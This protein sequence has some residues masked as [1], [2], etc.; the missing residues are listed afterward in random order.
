MKIKKDL[1]VVIVCIVLIMVVP[2]PVTYKDG[3]T[4]A[5]NALSYKI[6]KWNRLVA[7][8]E[9]DNE[10]VE[11]GCYH[12]T[13]VYLFPKNFM[14]IDWLYSKEY[15]KFEHKHDPNAPEKFVW[16]ESTE[17]NEKVK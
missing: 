1:L 2:I 9:E 4:K 17:I 10:Y 8:D 16:K 11:N 13:S 3:G 5:Y 6:V 15:E 14:F 7:P 12:K